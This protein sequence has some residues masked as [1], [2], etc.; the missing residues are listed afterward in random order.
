MSFFI[1]KVVKG[2]K[3]LSCTMLAL[4]ITIV[5]FQVFFRYVLSQPIFWA[6]ELVRILFVWMILIGLCISVQEG[7]QAAVSVIIDKIVK[8]SKGRS[9]VAIT[10]NFLILLF[11]AV[12]L[13]AGIKIS[14]FVH[15][16][17]FPALGVSYTVQYAAMPVAAAMLVLICINQIVKQMKGIKELN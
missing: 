3:I 9:V 6:E 14:A 12:L 10:I 5:I 13:Y 2:L 1:E 17:I 15:I 16:Q 8:S 4:I 11:S 7:S